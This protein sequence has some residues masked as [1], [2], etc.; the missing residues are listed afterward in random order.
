MI[1]IR[2]KE[3]GKYDKALAEKQGISVEKL[4][5][6]R[7][8]INETGTVN[9][10]INL[11]E[12]GSDGHKGVT[13]VAKKHGFSNGHVKNVNEL[14]LEDYKGR[15]EIL[16]NSSN[17]GNVKKR[18]YNY[19]HK[20]SKGWTNMGL[21]Q[22]NEQRLEGKKMAQDVGKANLEHHNRL[23]E[24]ATV[25][26][27]HNTVT[28]S[29]QPAPTVSSSNAGTG[30]STPNTVQETVKESV[31]TTKSTPSTKM[32]EVDKKLTENAAK[33]KMLKNLGKG[34]LIVG[35][36]VAAGIGAKK[37]YDKKKAKPEQKEIG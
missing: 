1:I 4:R 2:Q 36:T 19:V 8:I 31:K 34:A 21:E 20:N 18:S 22:L 5:Q 27:S 15:K 32:V 10:A 37:L 3:F 33:S 17:P 23:K 14:M 30:K 29:S 13:R 25:T 6:N 24:K 7:S 12:N 16:S 9:D 35:G 11:R 28:A 26:P